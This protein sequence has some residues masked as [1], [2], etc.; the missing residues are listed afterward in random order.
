M[1]A[2]QKH[3][4][5]KF[6]LQHCLIKAFVR[7][8]VGGKLVRGIRISPA[9]KPP[10]RRLHLP[11]CLYHSSVIF[12]GRRWWW[13]KQTPILFLNASSSQMTRLQQQPI[14][15][16]NLLVCSRMWCCQSWLSRP[17]PCTDCQGC[18]ETMLRIIT[19]INCTAIHFFCVQSIEHHKAT[20]VT[21][22]WQ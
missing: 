5:L 19:L 1:S 9:R 21:W 22:W 12:H 16:H 14:I 10:Q 3:V 2:N 15:L 7:T 6:H 11:L 8:F 20:C 17:G 13:T 18:W 4:H